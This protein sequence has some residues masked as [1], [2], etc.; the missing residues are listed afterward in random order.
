MKETVML[1]KLRITLT[2]TLV[3]LVAVSA[4]DSTSA[5]IVFDAGAR[6]AGPSGGFYWLSDG[7]ILGGP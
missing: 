3:A 2:A 4:A 7:T 1:H 6:F 5:A